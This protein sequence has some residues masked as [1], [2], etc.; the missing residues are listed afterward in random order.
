[1]STDEASPATLEGQVRTFLQR[2]FPQIEM[3]GGD[4]TV[5]ECDPETG[6]ATVRLS[7]ACSGCGISPMTV[8]AIKARLPEEI[9]TIE[10]VSVDVGTEPE[11]GDEGGDHHGGM[12]GHPAA[13]GANMQIDESEVPDW[14]KDD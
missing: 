11:E 4:A 5:C 6:V 10:E 7:G 2:N 14:R 9:A 8:Q 3:H 12:G 1:M 13:G